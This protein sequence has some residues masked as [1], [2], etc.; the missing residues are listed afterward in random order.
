MCASTFSNQ[1]KV[2]LNTRDIFTPHNA[3]SMLRVRKAGRARAVHGAWQTE[4][5]SRSQPQN[6]PLKLR[7][8]K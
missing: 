3:C 1:V 2:N 7:F 4:A 6:Y 8:G 5:R